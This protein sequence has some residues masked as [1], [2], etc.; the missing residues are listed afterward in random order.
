M[1]DMNIIFYW[2]RSNS[3]S[4]RK[5]GY[6]TPAPGAGAVAGAGGINRGEPGPGYSCTGR[7]HDPQ[8]G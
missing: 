3:I 1:S 4:A 8:L 5:F 6:D 2:C 7:P